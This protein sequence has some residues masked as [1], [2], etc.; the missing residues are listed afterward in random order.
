MLSRSPS[1]FPS[2]LIS[3]I[4]MY[5][6]HAGLGECLSSVLLND[7]DGGNEGDAWDAGEGVQMDD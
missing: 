4:G 7:S 5:D 3:L 6:S 1:C 2:G